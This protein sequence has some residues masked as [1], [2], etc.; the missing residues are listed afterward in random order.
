MDDLLDK[1]SDVYLYKID[2]DGCE[3]GFYLIE[4][5]MQRWFYDFANMLQGNYLFC[6]LT[7]HGS[8]NPEQPNYGALVDAIR[9]KEIAKIS[10]I[11]PTYLSAES[12]PVPTGDVDILLVNL[13]KL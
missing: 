2:C 3:P 5:G 10:E 1:D 12:I 8:Y 7:Q 6:V 9:S 4:T 13:D 11:V